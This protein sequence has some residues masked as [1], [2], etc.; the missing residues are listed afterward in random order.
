M[1]AESGLCQEETS[2]Q[3]R[4]GPV[5]PLHPTTPLITRPCCCCS[6]CDAVWLLEKYPWPSGKRRGRDARRPQDGC[7]PMGRPLGVGITWPP[8]RGP[9][10]SAGGA[11][12]CK[13][14]GQ[15]SSAGERGWG[16]TLQSQQPRDRTGKGRCGHTPALLPTQSN[17][18][19]K[20]E[21]DP[22]RFKDEGIKKET[23]RARRRGAV[24]GLLHRR[25]SKQIEQLLVESPDGSGVS[26]SCV[27]VVARRLVFFGRLKAPPWAA[28][29]ARQAPTVPL[30]T[31]VRAALGEFLFAGPW[32][33]RGAKQNQQDDHSG[34]RGVEA[35]VKSE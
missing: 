29:R 16:T 6:C 31:D 28:A 1:G 32:T 13:G 11:W 20:C 35:R 9:A 17:R 34:G 19:G 26:L 14:R 18:G 3:K 4:G 27:G 2:G 23:R 10:N 25:P 7:R 24:L 8:R 12:P 5:G 22:I 21:S 15:R 30:P 33:K